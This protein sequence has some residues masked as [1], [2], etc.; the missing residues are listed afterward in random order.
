MNIS[1]GKDKSVCQVMCKH[2][3]FSKLILKLL[4]N[5][6]RQMLYVMLTVCQSDVRQQCLNS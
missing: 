1:E 2:L 4:T 5:S 6:K 3:N